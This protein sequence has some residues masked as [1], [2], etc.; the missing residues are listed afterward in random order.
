MANSLN[1]VLVTI[2]GPEGTPGTAESRTH[3]VP[4]RGNPGLRAQYQKD[5]DPVI[6]GVNMMRQKLVMAGNVQGSIDLS[7]RCAPGFG[8]LVN[9]LLGQEDTPTQVAAAIRIRYTGSD[10]SCKISA[11]TSADTLTAETGTKGSES[12]DTN[13]G[14]AGVIDLT[15][16]ATDTVSELVAVI[17]AYTDYECEKLF[18][19]DATDTADI[20]DITSK[21]AKDGWVTVWF[22]SAASGVYRHLWPVILANTERPVYSIQIDGRQDNYLYDGCVANG[23]NLSAALKGFV[24]GSCD[25]LGFEQTGSQSASSLD[26]EEAEPFRFHNAGFSLEDSDYVYTRNISLAFA[27]NHNADGYG[28]GSIFRQYQEKAMFAL[29][30]DIQLRLN[31]TSIAEASNIN[32]SDLKNIYLTFKGK[33]DAFGTDLDELMGIE[34][35]YTSLDDFEWVENNG[36]LDARI[37]FEAVRGMNSPYNEAVTVWMLTD[38]SSAF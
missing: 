21:Q 20:E 19:A 27:N 1:N 29:T 13:F 17:A 15:A 9:S 36:V 30:G 38:D 32:T 34:I 10:A 5:P 8:K 6:S 28:T 3:V 31:S 33:D 2:G 25:I 16:S 14:T 26:L 23:M 12:G 18:G 37:P 22:T 35:P 7:P 4:H 11:D 24:E